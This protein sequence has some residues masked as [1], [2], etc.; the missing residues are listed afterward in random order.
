MSFNA[1]KLPVKRTAHGRIYL[2]RFA[3]LLNNT[4]NS[5]TE[6]TVTTYSR[7]FH[8]PDKINA[9][10]IRDPHPRGI[11]KGRISDHVRPLFSGHSQRINI[12]V[13]LNEAM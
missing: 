9:T 11:R 1:T 2:T 13:T 5:T 4:T 8:N 6:G 7:G 10:A 3:H 12:P